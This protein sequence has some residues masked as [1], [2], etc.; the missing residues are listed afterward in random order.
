MKQLW[1]QYA[2]KIDALSLRERLMVFAAVLAITM[3]LT[4]VLFVEP[5]LARAKLHKSRMAQQQAEIVALSTQAQMLEHKLADPDAANRAHR[6]ELKR[7]IAAID[8]KVKG[9]QQSLVPAQRVNGLL[10]DMLARNPRL[11]LV[12]MRTLAVTPLLAR[13]QMPAG[14]AAA[15][16]PA[17]ALAH[18][19]GMSTANVFK[20]GVDITL[21][22]NYADLH[23]YLLRLER[24]PWRMFWTRVKLDTDEYPRLTM[25]VTIHTLSLD[26]AWLQV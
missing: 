7:Q 21:R 10:Q 1:R 14:D 25:T 2:A 24:L 23:D 6:D 16:V 18:K 20:H 8:E 15:S 26:K 13:P 22:G 4:I 3:F 17:P 9:M 12:S 11:Q 5:P 19:P